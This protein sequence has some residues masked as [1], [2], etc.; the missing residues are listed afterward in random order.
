MAV[1]YSGI[2]KYIW[3][4]IQ[5]YD[6]EK[7]WKAREYVV[8]HKTS[9]KSYYYLYLVKKMDAR[10]NAS[11]GTHIGHKSA[12]FKKRPYLPHGL[13]GIIVSNDSVIGENCQIYHQVTIGG[14]N[15]G[16][17]IIGNNVL[18]YTKYIFISFMLWN[19]FIL[20]EY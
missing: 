19:N 1:T 13:N 16:S 12:T 6:Y 18:L 8:S 7:Y 2:K 5:K 15:G 11:L 10:H 20:L 9:I 3:N 14:G 4:K 17:P